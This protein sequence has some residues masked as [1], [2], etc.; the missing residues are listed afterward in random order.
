MCA[1]IVGLVV[2]GDV[3]L[4]NLLCFALWSPGKD[5]NVCKCELMMVVQ[6]GRNDFKES[7]CGEELKEIEATISGNRSSKDLPFSIR[8]MLREGVNQKC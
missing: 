3:G 4:C 5:G 6:K 1:K 8:R 7:W 2:S